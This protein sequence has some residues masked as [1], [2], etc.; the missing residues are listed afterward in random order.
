VEQPDDNAIPVDE[1]NDNAIRFSLRGLLAVVTYMAFTLALAT[2]TNSVAVGIHLSL[3]LA[4]W[5]LI[6]VAHGHPGG[7][8]PA[9]LGGD[10]LLCS[11]ASWVVYAREDFLGLR[12]IAD[13]FAS[14][15]LFVGFVVLIVVS[16]KKR[17]YWKRQHWIAMSI[18]GIVVVWWLSIPALGNAAIARR[19][20]ADFAANQ[21]AQGQA[22][23]MVEA[24]RKQLG[25]TPEKATLE[26]HLPE[27][28]PSVRWDGHL[29]K[30][31]YARISDTTYQ[32]YYLD[33]SMFVFGDIIT[34]D[35]ANPRK[36]WYRVP[37]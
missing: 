22:I 12:V 30:I 19:Q 17:R 7:I 5:I 11:S 4:G 6:R 28:F 23:E 27:P 32:L 1:P 29:Q 3:G 14:V 9:L 18:V 13:I 37:F 35:S 33:S 34:Y 31:T 25:T 8:V 36:G 10:I 20:A 26:E 2:A 16:E 24:V 21:A 15:L